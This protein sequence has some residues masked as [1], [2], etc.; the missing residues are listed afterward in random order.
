[1]AEKRGIGPRVVGVSVKP[2]IFFFLIH[3]WG[4]ELVDCRQRRFDYSI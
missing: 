3:K 2:C 4:L 1:M